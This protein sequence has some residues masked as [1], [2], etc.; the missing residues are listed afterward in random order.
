MG[1]DFEYVKH[2]D[3]VF[4]RRLAVGYLTLQFAL[5]REVKDIC[6]QRGIQVSLK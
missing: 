6:V 3:F 5:S 1:K 2:A 4:C